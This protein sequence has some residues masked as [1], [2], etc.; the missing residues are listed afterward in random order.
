MIFSS[1]DIFRLIGGDP[2]I[3]LLA[4]IQ[5][6]D[7]KPPLTGEEGLFIYIDRF[8]VVEEFEATWKIWVIDYS[9][10]PVEVVI[11]TLETILPKVKV[12]KTAVGYQLTT[13][14]FKSANTQ[15]KPTEEIRPVIAPDFSEWEDRFQTLV[16]DV[17]DQMLLVT[18][19][20]AGKDGQDGKDGKDGADGKDVLAT[21]ASIN[22]LQDVDLESKLALQKG[23]VL[24][25][26]GTAWT[27]LF[28]PQVYA[29]GAAGGGDGTGD[30]GAPSTTIQWKFH[31]EVGEPHDREFHTNNADPTLL[32]VL[33]VSFENNSGTDISSLLNGLLPST[34]S[35]YVYRVSE[36]SSA[37]LYSVT[38]YTTTTNG[39]EISVTHVETPGSEEDLT[40]N[41]I[42]GFT[43]IAAGSG[44]G[45][46][47]AANVIISDTAPTT[48]ANGLSLQEG[49]M[50]W[51]SDTGDLHIYY[52]NTW[53]RIGTSGGSGGGIQEAPQDGGYYVRRNGQ[54]VN[55]AVALGAFDNRS[56]DGGN[57]TT[58][59]GSNFDNAVMD[60]GNFTP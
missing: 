24:T 48:R 31:N 17:Q 2:V 36:P 6:V 21:E 19:G 1:A 20:R 59:T 10:E 51:E 16:E 52:D 33:H 56:F 34:E 25:W 11:D 45:A 40:N 53:V 15:V 55:L 30:A 37:H 18:S 3:R 43:F 27:N 12:S 22:D 44:V 49:D 32:T 13:T 47:P 5:I 41:A 38:G 26:D 28:I 50:W 8:P 23:H 39:V 4:Q 14:E 46:G 57:F 35:I 60:G 9:D 54:W 42:Y 7:G 29:T 58:G